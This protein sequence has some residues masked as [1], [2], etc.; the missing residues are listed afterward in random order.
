MAWAIG[1]CA[2]ATAS[3]EHVENITKVSEIG[4]AA[5]ATTESTA[6]ES[7]STKVW[8]IMTKR[9]I[10]LTFFSVGQNVVGFVDFFEFFFGLFVTWVDIGVIFT[11]ELA[12]CFLDVRI[13]GVFINP[14]H[15]IVIALFSH[16]LLSSTS[17]KS[18]S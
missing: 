12:E 15:L 13:A 2:A 14:E 18:A 3:E 7:A 4:A 8:R 10:L 11:R 6:A 9:I 5:E 1:L 16:Y 17:V